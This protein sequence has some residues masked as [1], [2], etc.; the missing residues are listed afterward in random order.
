MVYVICPECN[1]H[2]EI[3]NKSDVMNATYI[4]SICGYTEKISKLF[5]KGQ[6][7]Y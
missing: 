2:E 6:I 3:P 5:G 4:C 1:N 7:V